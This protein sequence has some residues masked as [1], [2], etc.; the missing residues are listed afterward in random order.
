MKHVFVWCKFNEIL[1]NMLSA[2]DVSTIYL[3]CQQTYVCQPLCLQPGL[4]KG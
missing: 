3:P 4:Y 1:V 2:D